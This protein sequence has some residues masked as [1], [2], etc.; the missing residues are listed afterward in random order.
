MLGGFADT[1]WLR[2][3][4]WLL[5]DTMKKVASAIKTPE[6][7]Q[8]LVSTVEDSAEL[9]EFQIMLSRPFT[10]DFWLNIFA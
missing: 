7:I 9:E 3:A 2:A 10:E 1:D 4:L 6:D 5:K 8:R